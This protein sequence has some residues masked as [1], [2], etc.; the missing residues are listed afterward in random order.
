ML[1]YFLFFS[2]VEIR[3]AIFSI[4]LE[5]M[6]YTDEVTFWLSGIIGQDSCHSYSLEYRGGHGSISFHK[7]P[8][9]WDSYPG[10]LFYAEQKA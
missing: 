2:T 6:T 4:F 1:F 10:I 5:T 7:K 9:R 3:W 8:E